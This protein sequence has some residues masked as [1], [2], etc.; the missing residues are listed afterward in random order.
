M[1]SPPATPQRTPLP[2]HP[3]AR[4]PPATSP[5][6]RAGSAFSPINAA[7]EPA[8]PPPPSPSP[9][10][11]PP[12]KP[13]RKG[14]T[15]AITSCERCRRAH[16]KCVGRGGGST[17]A[18]CE[19]C[20]RRGAAH[21]CSFV[22]RPAPRDAA[23]RREP[24][25]DEEDEEGPALRPVKADP[26]SRRAE[27]ERA[28]ARP[29]TRPADKRDSDPERARERERRRRRRLRALAESVL[30]RVEAAADVS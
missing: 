24:E 19:T 9:S 13:R 14:R 23:P 25:H 12:P 28:G 15:K 3:G 16:I 4:K 20:A 7:R 30:A 26:G 17:G 27:V 2:S 21:A 5:P 1:T 29:G 6:A 22:A 8:A 11:S 18:A 10:P